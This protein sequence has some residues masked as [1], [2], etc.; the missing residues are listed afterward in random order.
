MGILR[1]R[2]TVQAGEVAEAAGISRQAVHRH[3]RALVESG[4][5][6]PEGEGRATR[7]RLASRTKPRFRYPCAVLAEDR[8][9]D[10]AVARV[11]TLSALPGATQ[12]IVR[13]AL[14]SMLANAI[15]HSRSTEVEVL[16]ALSDDTAAFEV[17]DEGVGI[18][19]RVREGLGLASDLEAVQELAKGKVATIADGHRGEGIYLSSRI[20]ERFEI[21]SGEL[22]WIVDNTRSDYAITAAPVRAGSRVRFETSRSPRRTLHELLADAAGDGPFAKTQ[23]AVK[24]FSIGVRF[25]SRAEAR[26]LLFGLERFS[27]IVLDFSGVEGVGQG[28]VDEVFRAWTSKHSGTRLVPIGMSPPVA[29]MVERARHR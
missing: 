20:A 18:F 10:D 27:E 28:F 4:K 29:F 25:V 8:V 5:L 17:I 13:F 22:R 16:F 12:E 3:M 26:R 14:T 1:T 11:S 9:W 6:V 19:A 21:E 15:T 23:I 7:Y 24:L 2:R